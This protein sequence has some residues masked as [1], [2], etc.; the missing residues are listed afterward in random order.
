[1]WVYEC[2][3]SWQDGTGSRIYRTPIGAAKVNSELFRSEKIKR[4]C[5]NLQRDEKNIIMYTSTTKCVDVLSI[6]TV[7]HESTKPKF[8]NLPTSDAFRGSHWGRRGGHSHLPL[9]MYS[10]KIVVSSF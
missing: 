3:C 6:P 7:N 1:M 10:V 9:V 2:V 4:Q 8:T 5:W